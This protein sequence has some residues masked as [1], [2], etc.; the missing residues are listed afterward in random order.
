MEALNKQALENARRSV[1][2]R[3]SETSSLDDLGTYRSQL[4][5]QQ[6]AA[7]SKLNVAVSGKLDALKR[8]VDLM[9]ESS[10]SKPSKSSSHGSTTKKKNKSPKTLLKKV[11]YNN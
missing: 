10:S 2:A 8:A 3:F 4:Q 9:D 1:A 11:V 7:E 6:A 5:K